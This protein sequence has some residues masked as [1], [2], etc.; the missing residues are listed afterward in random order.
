MQNKGNISLSILILSCITVLS[1]CAFFNG[2]YQTPKV[3]QA[4]DI[5]NNVSFEE[6]AKIL[7]EKIDDLANGIVR[8]PAESDVPNE[9]NKTTNQPTPQSMPVVIQAGK[10]YTAILH[11]EEGDIEI[12]LFADK[13]PLTVNNF[14]LLSKNNFYD[15]TIFHRAISGFM[16]QGG[17]PKGDGTGNPGYTFD[18][19]PFSGE[20]KRGI[21]AMANSGPNTNGC[22]F[23]IMHKDYPLEKNY[24]IFGQV[25]KGLDVVDKIAEAPMEQS[26]S[27]E[28]SK[29]V[30]PVKIKNIDIIEK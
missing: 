7:E 9:E 5:K 15:N 20:Y 4:D 30:N 24:V 19:E 26:F 25:V 29:P 13:T 2:Q 8:E 10:Q 23:F 27:G 6:G 11:T 17:D 12:N 18:D 3:Y 16:I 28:N 22:Q 21:V 14:V 1:G